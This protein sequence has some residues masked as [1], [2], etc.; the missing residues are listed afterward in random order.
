MVP[1]EDKLIVLEEGGRIRVVSVEGDG[2][3][4]KEIMFEEDI[5][6]VVVH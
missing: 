2:K 1:W 3:V 4:D 5:L 6:D